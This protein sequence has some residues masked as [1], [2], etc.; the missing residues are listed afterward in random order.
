[1]DESL[2]IIYMHYG[3]MPFFLK[4]FVLY[5]CNILFHTDSLVVSIQSAVLLLLLLLKKMY[6]SLFSLIFLHTCTAWTHV[7]YMNIKAN[8][9]KQ[10][11]IWAWQPSFSIFSKASLPFF[12]FFFFFFFACFTHSLIVSYSYSFCLSFLFVYFLLLHFL[13]VWAEYNFALLCHFTFSCLL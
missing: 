9:Q 13:W 12:H 5:Y 8:R 2:D 11:S 4:G 1:L 7:K 3:S 6:Y 10:T